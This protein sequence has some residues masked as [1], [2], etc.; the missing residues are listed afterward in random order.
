[1]KQDRW[2]WAP[3]SGQGRTSQISARRGT[4][5]YHREAAYLAE[6]LPAG[7]VARRRR[8]TA[9]SRNPNPNPKDCDWIPEGGR[10]EEDGG[11][12]TWSSR[13]D[14][15]SRIGQSQISAVH[16]DGRPIF[17]IWTVMGT[18]QTRRVRFANLLSSLTMF[19]L[20]GSPTSLV[21]GYMHE[22]HVGP[23]FR[24][25]CLGVRWKTK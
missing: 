10:G 24:G 17:G 15:C 7:C 1:M 9:G 11:E 6:D 16:W 23:T 20:P 8:R 19:T 5:F 21:T 3:W 18:K 4:P 12:A 14:K 2:E 25:P 13:K 22:I